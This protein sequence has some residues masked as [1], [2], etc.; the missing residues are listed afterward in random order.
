M[1]INGSW[2]RS[3][4]HSSKEL[5]E[6]FNSDKI[7]GHKEIIKSCCLVFGKKWFDKKKN[8]PF[9]SR[10]LKFPLL[11]TNSSL[12]EKAC[13]AKICYKIAHI[14]NTHNSP[15]NNIEF[16]IYK[17][18]ENQFL[19]EYMDETGATYKRHY[20]CPLC[21]S[22]GHKV[23]LEKHYNYSCPRC[24]YLS[25][26]LD[27][28]FCEE[29]SLDC[30]AC[31][32]EDCKIHIPINL[33][34]NNLTCPFCLHKFGNEDEIVSCKL[35]QRYFLEESDIDNEEIPTYDLNEFSDFNHVKE[36]FINDKI[37]SLRVNNYYYTTVSLWNTFKKF[38]VEDIFAMNYMPIIESWI[39]YQLENYNTVP[40]S[41][42]V[43]DKVI[44]NH[45][46]LFKKNKY[47]ITNKNKSSALFRKFLR[48]REELK[49]FC[50]NYVRGEI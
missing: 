7:E 5:L 48:E 11:I 37:K 43:V 4:K 12:E 22:K 25:K 21:L 17:S 16:Y 39:K 3:C 32:N 46:I 27:G 44:D 26:T 35:P 20:V 2:P 40:Q 50:I 45:L 10:E 18:I 23:R 19:I 13:I 28:I 8:L 6:I 47:Y 33:L 14:V 41:V 34:K 30:I 9:I 15:K 36:K 1:D 29:I 24:V 31:P 38:S 42:K 49:S